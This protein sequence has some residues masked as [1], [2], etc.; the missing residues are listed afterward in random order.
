ML[1]TLHYITCNGGGNQNIPYY[2]LLPK[3]T[4]AMYWSLLIEGIIVS[5]TELVLAD[6]S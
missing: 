2:N 1:L 6:S 3:I 5:L 4:S